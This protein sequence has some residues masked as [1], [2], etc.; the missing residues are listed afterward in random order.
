[1][2]EDVFNT[3]HRRRTTNMPSH[4]IESDFLRMMDSEDVSEEEMEEYSST[5]HKG[6]VYNHKIFSL[7]VYIIRFKMFNS[8]FGFYMPFDR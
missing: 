5:S 8:Q 6:R 2:E 3:V 7:C 1:M 4:R